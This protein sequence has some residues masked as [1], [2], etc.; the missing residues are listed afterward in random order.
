M[1]EFENKKDKDE[2][3]E[4]EKIITNT[5]REI[6]KHENQIRDARSMSRNEFT[7]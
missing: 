2:D 4:E 3:L 1:I 7:K 6:R 5:R